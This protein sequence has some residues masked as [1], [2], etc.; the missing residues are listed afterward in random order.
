MGRH[1]RTLL[2]RIFDG[3]V[4]YA[5][6]LAIQVR[7][8]PTSGHPE[9]VTRAIPPMNPSVKADLDP[10]VP[11]QES[12]HA[13]RRASTVH[14]TLLVLQVCALISSTSPDATASQRCHHLPTLS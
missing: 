7:R 8:R 11:T 14:D 1:P 3:L 9:T 13:A 6:G 2:V 4:G 5:D 10:T 12:L